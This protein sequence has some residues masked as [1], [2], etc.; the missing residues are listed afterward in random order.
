MVSDFIRDSLSVSILSLSASKIISLG[1][2]SGRIAF[3]PLHALDY[4]FDFFYCCIV[5]RYIHPPPP[6]DFV[7]GFIVSLTFFCPHYVYWSAFSNLVKVFKDS[8][9]G[10]CNIQTTQVNFTPGLHCKNTSILNRCKPGVIKMQQ[11]ICWE[12]STK[13]IPDSLRRGQPESGGVLC[14]VS[15]MF[16]FTYLR[17]RYNI[18][19]LVVWYL[20][21]VNSSLH[22]LKWWQC[23]DKE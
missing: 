12:T 15:K 22:V 17:N 10:W 9:W 21:Y 20:Q 6:L 2:S 23:I 1:I 19:I 18:N 11:N 8:N 7:G 14:R 4:R 3:S 5:G 13:V 16:I